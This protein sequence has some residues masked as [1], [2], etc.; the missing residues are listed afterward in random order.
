MA[1]LAVCMSPPLTACASFSMVG[2]LKS[3]WIGTLAANWRLMA[4]AMATAWIEL[5]PRAK[6]SS[7]TE[8]SSSCRMWHQIW[9]IACSVAVRA[10]T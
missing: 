10:A 5:P 7:I 3:S 2:A 1:R 9:L 6:K 8:T 4:R